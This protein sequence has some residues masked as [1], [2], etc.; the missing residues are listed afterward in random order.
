MTDAAGWSYSGLAPLNGDLSGLEAALHSGRVSAAE[1]GY[2][3]EPQIVTEEVMAVGVGA[4]ARYLTASEAAAAGQEF[5]PTHTRFQLH[6]S[7]QA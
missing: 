4:D 2:T 3:D 5:V 1:R 6:W 7:D